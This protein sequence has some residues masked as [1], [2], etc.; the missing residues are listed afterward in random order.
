MSSIIPQSSPLVDKTSYYNDDVQKL[1]SQLMQAI[2]KSYGLTKKEILVILDRLRD[3]HKIVDNLRREQTLDMEER[4]QSLNTISNQLNQALH[5]MSIFDK[6]NENSRAEKTI[7]AQAAAAAAAVEAAAEKNSKAAAMVLAE[8]EFSQEFLELKMLIHSLS[9]DLNNLKSNGSSIAL[10][11]TICTRMDE[12]LSSSI[13]SIERNSMLVSGISS[14]L[15]NQEAGEKTD[16]QTFL[17]NG[18]KAEKKL[19]VINENYTSVL[20]NYFAALK[21]RFDNEFS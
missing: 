13:T 11:E 8:K 15:G 18:S 2:E 4:G 21:K 10:I 14:D 7:E 1:S 3:T 20:N 17:S 16:K 9:A 12:K 19:E 6:S 5:F